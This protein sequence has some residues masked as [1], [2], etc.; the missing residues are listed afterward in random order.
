M[1]KKNEVKYDHLEETD[2]DLIF[3]SICDYLDHRGS[4]VVIFH[5]FFSKPQIL[6]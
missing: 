4:E 6:P 5:D 1:F 2:L 3:D